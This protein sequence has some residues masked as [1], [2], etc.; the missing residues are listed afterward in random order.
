METRNELEDVPRDTQLDEGD[1]RIQ[2]NDL[3]RSEQTADEDAT[4]H[5]KQLAHDVYDKS[6]RLDVP[7]TSEVD[8]ATGAASMLEALVPLDSDENVT[9]LSDMQH[10]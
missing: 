6:L 3:A 10:N 1:P 5:D 4:M 2:L 8:L 9:T 7:V